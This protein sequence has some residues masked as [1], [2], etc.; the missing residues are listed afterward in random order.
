[1]NFAP[2]FTPAMVPP[3]L[4]YFIPAIESRDWLLDVL[5][6]SMMCH[7]YPSSNVR[8]GRQDGLWSTQGGQLIEAGTWKPPLL[9]FE[10]HDPSRGP[11]SMNEGLLSRLQSFQKLKSFKNTPGTA[12]ASSLTLLA[13][14]QQKQC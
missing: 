9:C 5:P 8:L 3:S 14:Y 13:I 10:L 4:Q 12:T 11:R 1:M 2:T 6:I 7:N